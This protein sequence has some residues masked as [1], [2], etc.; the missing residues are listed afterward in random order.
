MRTPPLVSSI[1]QSDVLR[2]GSCGHAVAVLTRHHQRQPAEL[3]PRGASGR[4]G[5]SLRAVLCA[6][7]E[8]DGV[9]VVQ[10]RFGARMA[11]SLVNDAPVTIVLDL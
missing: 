10:G 9:H 8:S 11:V 5:S 1:A 6:A 2:I 7:L 4:R 3:H